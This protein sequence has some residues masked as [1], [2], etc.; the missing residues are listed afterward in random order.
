MH[1][2]LPLI[3]LW[4]GPDTK[5]RVR[6]RPYWRP[7]AEVPQVAATRLDGDVEFSIVAR[8]RIAA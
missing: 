6:Y 3:E 7:V 5:G 1:S 2:K 4:S 8:V